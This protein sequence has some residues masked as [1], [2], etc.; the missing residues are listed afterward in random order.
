[1]RLPNN[2]SVLAQVKVMLSSLPLGSAVTIH[3]LMRAFPAHDQ[4]A[5]SAALSTLANSRYMKIEDKKIFS[6][7]VDKEGHQV[8]SNLKVY[9]LMEYPETE[10]KTKPVFNL[11]RKN[12]SDHAPIPLKDA[13]VKAGEMFDRVF[14]CN[15]N[16]KF[17]LEPLKV[18]GKEMIY[19]S[20]FP[21]HDSITGDQG[22]SRYEWTIGH[23]LKTFNPKRDVLAIFGDTM[24]FAMAIL[25]L[26]S[27]GVKKIN[28]ARFSVKN[29]NY[30][31]RELCVDNFSI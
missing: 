16:I 19:V 24:V 23:R 4:T 22:R 29:G 31:V 18:L 30:V 17:D 8:A 5:L 7:F 25:F 9:K 20:D 28:V 13:P 3:D 26:A 10:L 12:G 21:V 6:V 15:P 27:K 1:M 14:A 11:P 2:P